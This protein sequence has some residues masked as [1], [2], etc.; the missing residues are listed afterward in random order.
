MSAVIVLVLRI[1]LALALY[2]FLALALYLLWRGLRVRGSSEQSSPAHV[3]PLELRNIQSDRI[4]RFITPQI[5]IGRDPDCQLHVQDNTVSA[6]HARLSYHHRQ[7]WIEDLGSKN[8]TLVNQ[9]M[10]SEPSLLADG[11]EVRCGAL[12]LSVHLEIAKG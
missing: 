4:W 6:A 9:L 10:L 5:L 12:V 1:L 8:G 11:D 2:A 7:W 3:E